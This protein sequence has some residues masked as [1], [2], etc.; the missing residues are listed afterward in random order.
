MFYPTQGRI[1]GGHGAIPLNLYSWI[2]PWSDS[3]DLAY[4]VV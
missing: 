2:R 1:Q 3:L 4:L